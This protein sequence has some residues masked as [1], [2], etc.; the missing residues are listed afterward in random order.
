MNTKNKGLVLIE[1]AA[2][3]AI[4]GIILSVCVY[5]FR[6]AER[7]RLSSDMS[8]LQSDLR[9]IR[10]LSMSESVYTRMVL[11]SASSTYNIQKKT[12]EGKYV[13]IKS[14]KFDGSRFVS[15][16]PIGGIVEYTPRGTTG[17]ACTIVMSLGK[18]QGTLTVNVGSGRIK[19]KEIIKK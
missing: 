6:T 7:F 15:L 8:Q 9:Y 19:I 18:Y 13:I 11:Y 4:I 17:S 10:K 2:V 16:N 1:L 3:L 12:A 5:S 14:A